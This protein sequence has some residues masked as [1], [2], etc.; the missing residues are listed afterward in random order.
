MKTILVVLLFT[1]FCNAQ[2][3]IAFKDVEKLGKTVKQLNETYKPAIG[4]GGV[5]TNETDQQKH[6]EAYQQFLKS[7]GAF[8]KENNFK[9]EDDITRCFNR[10][11]IAPD[12]KIDYFLYQFKTPITPE[13]EKEFRV[14]LNEYIKAHNFG[15][16]APVKFAQCSPV[17]YAKG[18]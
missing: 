7:F 9:W 6:V 17:T 14:L 5:F 2:I 8:L 10:I 4:P 1:S 11:Y 3:G 13:Q 15:V 12:G 18:E 16:T